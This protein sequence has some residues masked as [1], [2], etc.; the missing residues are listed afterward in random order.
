[1]GQVFILSSASYFR[2]HLN[3][4]C[5]WISASWKHGKAFMA[6]S[7]WGASRSRSPGY[8]SWKDE[9]ILGTLGP[10][11]TTPRNVMHSLLTLLKQVWIKKANMPIH[12]IWLYRFMGFGLRSKKT[13]VEWVG[14]WMNT[15]STDCYDYCCAK[16]VRNDW[17][18][19]FS[20]NDSVEVWWEL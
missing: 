3:L 13:G 19:E 18:L 2:L 9:A 5:T 15:L 7:R 14:D 8:S 10:C 4:L 11:S 20:W 16:N 6:T 17:K 1:M 12:M